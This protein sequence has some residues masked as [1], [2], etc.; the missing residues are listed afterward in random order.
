MEAMEDVY[1]AV[2]AGDIDSIEKFVRRALSD[3]K[4]PKEILEQSL[5]PSMDYIGSEMENGS[6]FVPEVLLSARVMQAALNVLKPLLEESG[7]KM[8]GRIILGTVKGDIHDIGRKLVGL[9]L[10]GAGFEVYDLGNTVSPQTFVEAIEEIRPDIVGFSAL[11]TTTMAMMRTT[12][13]EI[14]KSGLKSNIKIMVG[15][16]PVTEDFSK[17]IG[18]DG[19]GRDAVAAVNLAKKFLHSG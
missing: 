4:T 19:Y 3:G 15:G 1:N 9:M 7:I 17:M 10:E 2:I 11:L 16:A 18:A 13:E 5:I 14:E 12:I 6:I 8:R